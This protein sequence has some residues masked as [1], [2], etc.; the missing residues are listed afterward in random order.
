MFP[1]AFDQRAAQQRGR[2]PRRVPSGAAPRGVQR[3]GREEHVDQVR[4]GDL[5]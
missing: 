1:G 2:G 5:K 3:H 4:S